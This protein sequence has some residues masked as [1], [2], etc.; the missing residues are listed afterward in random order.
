M[1]SGKHSRFSSLFYPIFFFFFLPDE[2][3]RYCLSFGWFLASI[4]LQ[5]RPVRW[6][7]DEEQRKLRLVDWR[8]ALTRPRA[9]ELETRCPRRV[10]FYS[11]R[12]MSSVADATADCGESLVRV[13]LSGC[14][15]PL[16]TSIGTTTT[17]SYRS[18]LHAFDY[19]PDS[20]LVSPRR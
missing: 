3:S 1:T 12:R 11:P 4:Y 9:R 7:E 2:R 15:D 18:T 14:E 17:L 8:W 5:E 13:R 20:L 19:V 10:E 16:C 6:S